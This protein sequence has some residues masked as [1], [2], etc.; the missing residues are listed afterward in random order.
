MQRLATAIILAALV[1]VPA[2]CIGVPRKAKTDP[3]PSWNEG[4]AKQA[5]LDFVARTTSVGPDFVPREE[6]IAV[7]DNDGTLWSEQPIYFQFAFAMDRVR[8]L[9]GSHPEWKSRQPFKAVIEND[10]AALAAT[11]EKGLLEVVMATHAN[12]T[13]DD[14]ERVAKEWIETA[15]HPKTRR[16]YKEMIYLPMVELLEFLRAN[17]FK[18]WIVSGG[19]IEFMRTICEEAYGIPPEQIIGSMM[20]TEFEIRDGI[21]VLV[22]QPEIEFMNDKGEKPVGIERAVGRRPILAFGNSDGDL[23]MLQWTTA[24]PGARF[25]GIVHHTDGE[26]EWAYDRKS[27]IGRLDKALDEAGERGWS[28]VDMKRDW[29][30]VYPFDAD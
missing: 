27:K 16:L 17:G 18:T 5:L 14:F 28:V 24:G 12:M 15:R 11:G 10:P 21:P 26:R 29:R 23:Q 3:L 13:T 4:P 22:Q 7:F 25:G 20:A 30:V 9:A 1:L 2:A 8:A 6:R 19:G